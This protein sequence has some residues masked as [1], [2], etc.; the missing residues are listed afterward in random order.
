MKRSRQRDEKRSSTASRPR[1]DRRRRPAI[2][3]RRSA[4]PPGRRKVVRRGGSQDPFDGYRSARPKHLPQERLHELP[5]L[6]SHRVPTDVVEPGAGEEVLRRAHN[7]ET[8]P[9]HQRERKDPLR[10]MPGN[11]VGVAYPP[12]VARM[13]GGEAGSRVGHHRA[14]TRE[15]AS[16]TE[17]VEPLDV[18]HRTV[19]RSGA[20]AVDV[21]PS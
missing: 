2:R 18:R 7:R 10:G 19:Y 6:D 3:R 4:S 5:G 17:S 13:R 16:C 21:D 20:L 8:A 9:Q 1:G 14:V 11:S 12:V 15:R